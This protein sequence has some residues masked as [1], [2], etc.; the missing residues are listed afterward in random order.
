MRAVYTEDP[1][2]VTEAPEIVY[3][4]GSEREARRAAARAL[5]R[6]TLRGLR[7]GP[8]R[9]GVIY[10]GADGVEGSYVEIY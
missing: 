4:G 5:G 1:S 2:R 7:Q 3:I 9:H 6:A 8:G 10:Y